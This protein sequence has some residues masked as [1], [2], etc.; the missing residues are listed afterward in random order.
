[1]NQRSLL[2]P[3]WRSSKTPANIKNLFLGLESA[4]LVL[5]YYIGQT[6]SRLTPQLWKP[7][8]VCE[9]VCVCV[10]VCV[11]V[12][13]EGRS[14]ACSWIV[15][16]PI[17]ALFVCAPMASGATVPSL[18]G[19][20]STEFWLAHSKAPLPSVRTAVGWTGSPRCHEGSQLPRLFGAV[21][22]HSSG[23][24]IAQNLGFQSLLWVSIDWSLKLSCCHDRLK[25]DSWPTCLGTKGES[26]L[27]WANCL[28]PSS[29]WL[30][31]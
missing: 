2:Y 24:F 1:M 28:T 8:H 4:T 11:C 6:P 18:T 12:W 19:S 3:R 5:E 31:H 23:D 9:W 25:T 22:T 13:E 10:C 26:G 29:F 21:T 7:A 27:Y 16:P 14:H 30:L 20:P 17:R 15:I